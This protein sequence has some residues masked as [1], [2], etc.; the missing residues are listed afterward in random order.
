MALIENAKPKEVSG[1]YT[2][3]L[4]IAQ[5]STLISK[6]QSAVI[7]SGTE[8]EKCITK[9]VAKIDNLELFLQSEIMNDE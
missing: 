7:S 9:R 8:L 2:R 4:G 1:G 6:V 5:L 3:L